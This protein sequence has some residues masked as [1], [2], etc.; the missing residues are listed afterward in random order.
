MYFSCPSVWI[1]ADLLDDPPAR[2]L[3]EI[4]KSIFGNDEITE[5]LKTV[6]RGKIGAP[7]G[8]GDFYSYTIYY[9]ENVECCKKKKRVKYIIFFLN[10]FTTV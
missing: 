3:P 6:S 7:G 5:S 8:G 2:V 4:R 9:G 10:I 1:Y